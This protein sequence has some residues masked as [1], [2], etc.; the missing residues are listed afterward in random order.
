MATTMFER[1][2]E[3]IQARLWA[4]V[5]VLAGLLAVTTAHAADEF[6]EFTEAYLSDPAHIDN[7]KEL[8]ADQCR[9]CHGRSAYP[10]KGPKL[11]PRRYEP[12]FV[13]A[14]IAYGFRK[15]PAWGDVYST[16][17]I[18]DLVAFIMSDNFSP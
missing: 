9:H 16:E 11:V 12:D 18:K 15:M 10:G 4:P 7:G 1:S 13:Y 3:P 14:R 2:G 6:P 8:W 5:A 17:E